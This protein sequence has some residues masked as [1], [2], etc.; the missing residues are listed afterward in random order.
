M[1]GEVLPLVGMLA[2]IVAILVLAYFFTRYVAGRGLGKFFPQG[3]GQ[4][5][6][7]DQLSLGKDQRLAV[8]QAG[9]RHLLLGVTPSGVTLLAELTAEEAQLWRRETGGDVPKPP[10]FQ[11]ALL[12]Q[13]K[14]KKD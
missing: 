10:S 9:A 7:L 1:L 11:E 14:K 8:V 13:L 4:L 6:L 2:V 3:A 5:R 12:A